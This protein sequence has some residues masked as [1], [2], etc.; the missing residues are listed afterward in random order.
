MI[1]MLIEPSSI[2]FKLKWRHLWSF[3]P[4][5]WDL[6]LRWQIILGTVHLLDHLPDTYWTT[7]L[8][9]LDHLPDT[10]W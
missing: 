2:A 1:S 8:T 4:I 3:K 6:I 10:Y 9:I 5:V 7:Y